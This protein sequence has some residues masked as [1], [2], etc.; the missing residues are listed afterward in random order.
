MI[1]LNVQ[2]SIEINTITIDWIYFMCHWSNMYNNWN[3]G[4]SWT[5]IPFHAASIRRRV[6]VQMSVFSTSHSIE[7]IYTWIN[8]CQICSCTLYTR[9]KP[10]YAT[11]CFRCTLTHE[12]KCK[13]KRES[14]KAKK[15][16]LNV[17]SFCKCRFVYTFLMF[18]LCRLL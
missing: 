6:L 10:Q 5:F 2:N 14:E 1:W 4:L 13:T 12:T 9:Q 11:R 18:V 3:Y 17:N 7:W 16:G 8:I 15:N